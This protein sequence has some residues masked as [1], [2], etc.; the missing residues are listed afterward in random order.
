MVEDIIT[1]LSRVKWFFVIARN[2]SFTY[3]GKHVDTRQAGRELGV[4]YVLEEGSIRKSRQSDQDHGTAHRSDNRQ[5]RLGR[6]VRG[7]LEDVFELQDRIT[8]TVVTTIEPG[9]ELAEIRPGNFKPTNKL[10]AYELYL[11]ALALSYTHRDREGNDATLRLLDQAIVLDPNYA[12]AKAF[13]AQ[14]IHFYA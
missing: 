3:K 4:R 2:S 9:L 5:P 13:A 8:E 1:A 7:E 6:Q 14:L 10:D 11:R 12:F